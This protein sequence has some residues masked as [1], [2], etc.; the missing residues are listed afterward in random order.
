MVD[1]DSQGGIPC[2]LTIF[3][4]RDFIQDTMMIMMRRR[5]ADLPNA[6]LEAGNQEATVEGV[7]LGGLPEPSDAVVVVDMAGGWGPLQGDEDADGDGRD[8]QERDY[9][10]SGAHHMTI[11]AAL[12]SYLLCEFYFVF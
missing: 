3:D 6:A 10:L 1:E 8:Q 4:C 5:K 2:Q 9:K 12:L 11:N 7:P